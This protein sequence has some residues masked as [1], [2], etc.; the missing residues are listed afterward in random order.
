MVITI[1]AILL[2]WGPLKTNHEF[3]FLLTRGLNTDPLENIFGSICQ[4]G[5]NSDNPTPVQCTRAFRK[6]FF[7]SFLNTSSANCAEDFNDL[8]GQCAEKPNV[9]I[10]VATPSQPQMPQTLDI[11]PTDYRELHVSSNLMRASSIAYVSGSLLQKC[12]KQH[13]CQT[14]TTALVS[15]ELDDERKLF[16][17]FKAC[18]SDKGTF[19]ALHAPTIPY[20]EYVTQLE[21][22]FILVQYIPKVL[23]LVKPSWIN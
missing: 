1:N 11:G 15:N 3:K 17:Y 23:V 22:L 7:S 8:L 6:L 10:V 18:E 21:D 2:I 20:L 5:G 14:C 19:G 13:C 9:P 16:S 12:F 4:Q